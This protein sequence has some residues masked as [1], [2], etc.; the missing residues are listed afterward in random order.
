[1]TDVDWNLQLAEQLDWHWRGQLRPRL[2]GMTDA[3]YRWEPVPGAWN[4]RP[5]GTGTAPVSAG[6]GD[7]TV[8]FAMPAPVPAPVTTIAWRIGHIVVGVLG[9]R[10]A[11]HFGGPAV[12]YSSHRYPGDA[13][14]ALAQLD[15]AYALWIAGVRGLGADG[16]ARAC[17]PAEGPWASSSMA[18]LVLHINREM[19]H[20]GAEIALLRDLYLWHYDAQQ[21][22]S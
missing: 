8:D 7:F 4:A 10:V 13:A 14:S 21:L 11:S 17:G 5:R 3:E 18:E 15:A 2:D 6:T 1:M 12:D 22:G 20:H 16:L 19:L 9:M